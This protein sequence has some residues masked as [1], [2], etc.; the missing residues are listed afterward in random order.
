M[1][2]PIIR[3]VVSI[4]STGPG[5][6]ETASWSRYRRIVA[7]NSATS[8]ARTFP[9]GLAVPIAGSSARCGCAVEVKHD[10]VE[11][12]HLR[13]EDLPDVPAAGRQGR[14]T[15]HGSGVRVTGGDHADHRELRQR[16]PH[17]A[18]GLDGTSHIRSPPKQAWSFRAGKASGPYRPAGHST[19]FRT[20]RRPFAP[21]LLCLARPKR[22]V[23]SIVS[24]CVDNLLK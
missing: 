9:V 20:G 18:E 12:E 22:I 21:P 11:A 4:V 19:G 8:A 5:R 23:R 13:S 10:R 1:K 3:N 7:V 16:R 14:D 6:S 15:C 17:S 24:A 2:R